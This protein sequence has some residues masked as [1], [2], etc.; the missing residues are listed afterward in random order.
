MSKSKRSQQWRINVRN[1]KRKRDYKDTTW[2]LRVRE[3]FVF[4]CK[5]LNATA[6]ISH[7]YLLLKMT[8]IKM[9]ITYRFLY[10]W[11]MKSAKPSLGSFKN[12]VI[13]WWGRYKKAQR[14]LVNIGGFTGLVSVISVLFNQTVRCSG[15]AQQPETHLDRTAELCAAPSW[16]WRPVEPFPLVAE[17]CGRNGTRDL[18]RSLT[19]EVIVT[20]NHL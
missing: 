6:A 15:T 16:I 4:C 9:L 1:K 19:D 5:H 13:Y 20:W 10:V 18:S 14:F 8:F 11:Y 7:F 2:W 3:F 17:A 12:K